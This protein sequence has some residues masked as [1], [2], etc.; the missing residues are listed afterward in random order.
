MIVDGP[1]FQATDEGELIF[2]LTDGDSSRRPTEHDVV[3][4]DEE[5]TL[6][7]NYYLRIPLDHPDSHR[8]RAEIAK[9]LAP[10]V[11]GGKSTYAYA[12]PRILC[13]FLEMHTH[14]P[15]PKTDPMTS[16]SSQKKKTATM[17]RLPW[18]LAAFPTGYEL[19]LH[20][21]PRPSNSSSTSSSAPRRDFL[22]YGACTVPH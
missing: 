20:K 14:G 22:L 6:R 13:S 17:G 7:D 4:L 9:Y 5:S 10:L 12:P 2:L 19:Y 16:V 1:H 3:E 8:W 18:T 21:S 15:H 11:L